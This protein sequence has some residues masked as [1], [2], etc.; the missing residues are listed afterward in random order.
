LIQKKLT[1]NY[2]IGILSKNEKIISA[3][4]NVLAAIKKGHDIDFTTSSVRPDQIGRD[5]FADL[6]LAPMSG[7]SACQFL[8]Q[9][10][11]DLHCRCPL[12]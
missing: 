5:R 4:G 1:L 6:L 8:K 7:S 2:K 3:I 9:I 11:F 12:I 10:S